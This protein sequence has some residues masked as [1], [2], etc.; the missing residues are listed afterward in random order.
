MIPKNSERVFRGILFDVYHWKQKQFDGS[1]KTFE[2]IKRKPGVQLIVTVE[3]KLMLMQEEQPFVGKFI[4][5]PGGILDEKNPK[6]GVLRELKEET[7]MSSKNVEFWRKTDFSSKVNW[8]TYYYFVKDCKKI[9]A[10]N[11]DAGEKITPFLVSFEEFVDITSREDFRN[12]EFSNYMFRLKHDSKKLEEFKK[13]V[14][15]KEKKVT[16][17][18]RKIKQVIKRKISKKGEYNHLFSN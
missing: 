15:G 12:K 4:G 2:A 9:S 11:L 8:I 17:V 7:G 6:K 18:K 13:L 10:Q 16:R 14:F 1:Y 3:D 5:L